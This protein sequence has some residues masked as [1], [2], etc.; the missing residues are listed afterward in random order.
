MGAKTIETSTP[1]VTLDAIQV[2][3]NQSIDPD[4]SLPDQ[5]QHEISTAGEKRASVHE[6]IRMPVTYDDDLLGRE[7]PKDKIAGLE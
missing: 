4:L 3:H 2:N 1:K 6:R 5:S 7:D